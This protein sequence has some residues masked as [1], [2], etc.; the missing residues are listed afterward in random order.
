MINVMCGFDTTNKEVSERP[1]NSFFVIVNTFNVINIIMSI[2]LQV[3]TKPLPRVVAFVRIFLEK[4]NPLRCSQ[5]YVKSTA[6]Y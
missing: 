4:H 1:F 2:T 5:K 3:F 6:I